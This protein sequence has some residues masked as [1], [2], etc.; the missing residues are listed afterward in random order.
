MASPPEWPLWAPGLKSSENFLYEGESRTLG[1]AGDPEFRVTLMPSTP[2]I[3][4]P[5]DSPGVQGDGAL[6]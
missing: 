6:K 2:Q 5:T 4:P 3:T 1:E